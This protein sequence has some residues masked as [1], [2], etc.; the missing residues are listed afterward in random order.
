MLESHVTNTIAALAALAHSTAGWGVAEP[1]W[2][3][4]P[5]IGCVSPLRALV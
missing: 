4:H 1:T 5:A 2:L 3:T